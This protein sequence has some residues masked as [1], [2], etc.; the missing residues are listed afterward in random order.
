MNLEMA[1]GL[2]DRLELGVRT[3]LRFGNV[4]DRAVHP[5]EYGRL[6]DREYVDGALGTVA[7]PEVR[8]RG[9]LLRGP[10]VELGLEGR[11]F[12]P[13]EGNRPRS[14]SG[15]RW[16]STWAKGYGSIPACGCRSC[17]T[18]RRRSAFPSRSIYGF[19]SSHA[20]GWD[21]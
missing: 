10:V 12:V 20:S 4:V 14:N 11:L 17:S 15:Y 13:V 7:N 19:R 1:V 2:T 16:R 18:T 21:R 8:V 6:F 9:A 5:D 3:G